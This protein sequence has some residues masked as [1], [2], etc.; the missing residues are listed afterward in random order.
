MKPARLAVLGIALAAGAGA[1]LLRPA[2]QPVQQAS[3]PP[4]PVPTVDVLVAAVDIPLGNRLQSSDLRWAAWPAD[5][6]PAGVIRRTEAP[7]AETEIAGQLARAQVFASE[8]IRRER[9]MKSDGSGFLSAVLPSGKRAVAITIDN[10]GANSAGG[11]ILPNDRVDV[12]RTRRDDAASRAQSAD[13][14][15]SETILSNIRFWRSARTFRSAMARRSSPARRRRLSLIRARPRRSRLPS[16][17]ATSHWHFA[18]SLTPLSR[19]KPMPAMT[20]A[21]PS[22]ATA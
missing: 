20:P 6:V 1:F 19:P 12:I 4:T 16:A 18:A 8:P 21:L 2:P 11:F 14:M 10:R 9:L 3:A 13:V 22:S 17:P 5:S 7:S 15:M